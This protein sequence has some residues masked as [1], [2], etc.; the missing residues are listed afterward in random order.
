MKIELSNLFDSNVQI[1]QQNYNLV[2]KFFL[3]LLQ[4]TCTSVQC[5]SVP[6][7]LVLVKLLFHFSKITLY[8]SFDEFGRTGNLFSN[9]CIQCVIL[10]KKN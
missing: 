1:N 7:L 2:C 4:Y 5:V 6:K 10:K 3:A 9:I 8:N